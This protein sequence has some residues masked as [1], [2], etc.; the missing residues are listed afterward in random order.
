MGLPLMEQFGL[1]NVCVLGF[2]LALLG[3][4][5]GQDKAPHPG[6]LLSQQICQTAPDP[7]RIVP[8]SCSGVDNIL[9]DAD[10]A[11]TVGMAVIEIR[12]GTAAF[13]RGKPYMA[14]SVRNDQWCVFHRSDPWIRGGGHP[15]ICLSKKDGRV[16]S[17]GRSL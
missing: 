8:S 2:W 12:Y 10:A 1:R 16:L 13:E 17:I 5:T 3:I 14:A 9:P 7:D 11:L 4:G 15:E 6:Q